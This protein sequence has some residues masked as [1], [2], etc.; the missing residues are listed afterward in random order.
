[1]VFAATS[2]GAAIINN[3]GNGSNRTMRTNENDLFILATPH[4]VHSNTADGLAIKVPKVDTR[5]QKCVANGLPRMGER[6]VLACHLRI[7][8]QSRFDIRGIASSNGH[9]ALRR[10]VS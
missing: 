9:R 5:Q 10:L 3:A 1:M 8:S 7:L 6:W 2:D 4:A